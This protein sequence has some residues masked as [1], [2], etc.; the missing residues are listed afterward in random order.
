MYSITTI[1]CIILLYYFYYAFIQYR[2]NILHTYI[3]QI[4]T[5]K[6]CMIVYY[7]LCMCDCMNMCVCKLEPGRKLFIKE[8]KSQVTV[9][10]TQNEKKSDKVEMLFWHDRCGE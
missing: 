10:K 7:C 3:I 2:Y 9:H 6:G 1:F 5:T 4:V 8:E